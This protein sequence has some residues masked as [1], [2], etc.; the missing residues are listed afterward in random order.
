MLD[1]FW[2]FS[3]IAIIGL[4]ISIPYFFFSKAII[5]IPIEIDGKPILAEDP[6][7]KL[8]LTLFIIAYCFFVFGLFQLRKVL[9]LFSKKIIFEHPNILLLNK[10]GQNFL[11]ASLIS[12]IALFLFHLFIKG[13]A[14]LE[15]GGGFNSLLFTAS[16]GLFFMVLSEVF[17][18]AKNMKEEND[19]TI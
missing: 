16:L 4:F 10:V 8:V 6:V 13:Q 19:L 5:N 18:I 1:L 15:F 17:E 11:Y 3:I 14:V 7:T 9:D 2:Y 12:G